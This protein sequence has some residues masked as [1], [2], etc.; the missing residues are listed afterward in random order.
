MVCQWKSIIDVIA[1]PLSVVLNACLSKGY[2]PTALKLARTVPIFK[3][4]DPTALK[5]Y[6]PISIIPALAKIFEAFMKIQLMDHFESNNLF[7]SV[8]HGFRRS[9]STVTAVSKLVGDILDF[10]EEGDSVALALADLSKAFEFVPHDILL[11]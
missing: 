10:F 11:E 5:S 2:I 3:K 6:R 8:Q 7:S 1:H 9:K 4:G